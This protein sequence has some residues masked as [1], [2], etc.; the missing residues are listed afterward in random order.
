MTLITSGC[1]MQ[2]VDSA[3][4]MRK[5]AEWQAKEAQKPAVKA[6]AGDQAGAPKKVGHGLQLQSLWIIPVDNPCCSCKLTRPDDD[7]K[8]T[9]QEVLTDL[10]AEMITFGMASQVRSRLTAAIPMS[11]PYCSCRLT[12]RW[13]GRHHC[14]ERERPVQA[15]HAEPL[16]LD[17]GAESRKETASR[18]DPSSRRLGAGPHNME[19]PSKTWL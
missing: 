6:P 9:E 19:Y 3:A 12:R 5:A 15:L 10:F 16:Y 7:M 13:L 4:A 1:D 17:V 2:L 18:S 11:N 8:Q 14:D